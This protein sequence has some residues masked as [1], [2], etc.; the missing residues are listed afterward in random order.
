MVDR[1][2]QDI[3]VL[4]ARLGRRVSEPTE[5]DGDGDGEA[6]ADGETNTGTGTA[7]APTPM[8]VDDGGDGEGDNG[9]A[10]SVVSTRSGRSRK[11]VC[12]ALSCGRHSIDQIP[13]DSTLDVGIVDRYDCFCFNERREEEA[14]ACLIMV[15]YF[16]YNYSSAKLMSP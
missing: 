12:I 8:N 1:V 5:A 4:N 2:E 13:V 10:Q 14:E 7:A 3:R 15:S 16:T 6:D 9:R 11:Q